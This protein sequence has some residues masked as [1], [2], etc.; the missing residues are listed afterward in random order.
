MGR[1]VDVDDLVSSRE[2]VERLALSRVQVVH[3][4]LVSDE[5]FPRPVREIG[6][7][8]GGTKLWVWPDVREWALATGRM[9]PDGTP[10]PRPPRG[11]ARK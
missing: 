10:T 1:W 4:F 6:G 9:A 8:P 7:G 5:S 2:I 3:W 11:S